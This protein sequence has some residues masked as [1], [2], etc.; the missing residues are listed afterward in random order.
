[1]KSTFSRM[2]AVALTA[3]LGFAA[4]TAN[5]TVTTPVFDGNVTDGYTA[6]FG[7]TGL[8]SSFND[9][10]PFTIPSGTSGAGSANANGGRI[11]ATLQ[12]VAFNW[13]NLTDSAHNILFT[14]TIGPGNV[15]GFDFSGLSS[16]TTYDLNLNGVLA[17]GKSIGS[18]S[19]NINVNPVP[20]PE[21]YA[22][23]LVGLGLLGFSARRRN[24]NT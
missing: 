14:G 19:G 2:A 20:E 1:M 8:T 24:E 5:A 17:N 9:W 10:L 15:W 3:W 4:G 12:N 22:M 16:S 13:F 23:M 6:I 7:H 18:Y 21:I 11:S